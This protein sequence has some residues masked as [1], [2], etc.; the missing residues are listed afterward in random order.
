[1]RFVNRR[2]WLLGALLL[3]LTTLPAM[4]HHGF[5]A[6]YDPEAYI[7]LEGVV[8]K[9]EFVN[10]HSFV[11]VETTNESGETAVRWC[12]M[13]ARTQL[14]RKGI[15]QASFSVGDRVTIEG[16]QARR[17]PLGCEFGVGRLA[18][19]TVLALRS[20]D[21]QSQY[22]AP[23]VAGDQS[24]VG[25]WFRKAFP[26][27]G[28]NPRPGQHLTPAGEA[29]HAPY[30]P[31]TQNPSLSCSPVSPVQSWSQP[32]MPTRI[33]REEDTIV[34]HHEF[35]DVVR[36]VHLNLTEHPAD[37][38][39]TV[40]GHSIGRFEDGDLLIE[41][42]MFSEGNLSGAML[43]SADFELSERLRINPKNGDLEITWTATDPRTTRSLWRAHGL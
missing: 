8:A 1:M 26:G 25:S 2:E 19:G 10:P 23:L 29:A 34:V 9:F 40:M 16:F 41:T 20:R 21:G 3:T 28:T 30:D 35:M 13:Q 7:T 27:A 18:D 42:A 38:E 17:D 24:V 37:V 36:T 14:A 43:H 15:T 12:E 6:H 39:R 5:A 33:R 22:S 4:A 31:V 32:G 11:Y